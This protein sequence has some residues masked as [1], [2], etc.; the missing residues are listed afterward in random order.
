MT[1]TGPGRVA[2]REI[3][4]TSSVRRDRESGL[5]GAGIDV[6]EPNR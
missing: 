1:R 3:H 6:E 2:D 4:P 5:P